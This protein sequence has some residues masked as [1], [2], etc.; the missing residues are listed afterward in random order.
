MFGKKS[1]TTL[2]LIVTVLF[3][4]VGSV[5]AAPTSQETTPITGTIDTVVLETDSA[6]VTTVLVTLTDDL[7]ATQTV[8]LS[9]ETAVGLGLRGHRDPSHSIEIAVTA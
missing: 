2:L 7:G 1:I 6:G 4:Q 8:R 3:A 5:L 9:L